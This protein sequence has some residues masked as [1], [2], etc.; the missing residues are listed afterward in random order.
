MPLRTEAPATARGMAVRFLPPGEDEWRTGM[1]DIPVFAINAASGSTDPSLVAVPDPATG[2]PDPAKIQ[3]VL[4][5]HPE[6][7]RALAIVAKQQVSSGLA[8]PELKAF[9]FVDAAGQTIP[10]RWSPV[11]VQPFEPAGPAVRTE[12]YALFDGVL[13]LIAQHPPQWQLMVTGPGDPTKGATVAWPGDRARI[14]TRLVTID[15]AESPES[16]PCAAIN[17]HATVLRTGT[18]PSDD[19]PL[20]ARFSA[21]ARSFTVGSQARDEKLPSAA[22]SRTASHAEDPS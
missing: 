12:Q 10:V 19:P 15:H 9:R 20:S 6:A 14:D 11:P 18:E 1:S 16:L 2:K 3:A 8:N 22:G 17:D 13:N 5:A 4:A 7:V 21:Y